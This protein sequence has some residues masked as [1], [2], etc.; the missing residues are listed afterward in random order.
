MNGTYRYVIPV[1]PIE[2]WPGEMRK[3]YQRG[4]S[5]FKAKW[6]DTESLLNRELGAI[7][8]KNA[9][10]HMDVRERD[11]RQDGQLRANARPNGPAVMIAFNHPKLGAL[12][13]R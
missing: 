11:I 1:R 6:S 7:R 2:T 12:A 13:Y 8:A 3:Q 5:R 10:I 4:Y 9:V